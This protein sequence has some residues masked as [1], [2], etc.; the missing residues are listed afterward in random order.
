MEAA[1]GRV[2]EALDYLAHWNINAAAKCGGA[3]VPRLRPILTANLRRRGVGDA[4]TGLFTKRTYT[5]KRAYSERPRPAKHTT[6]CAKITAVPC[7]VHYPTAAPAHY[8][9]VTMLMCGS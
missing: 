6:A 9:I 2:T 4:P 5:T 8:L 7:T 1:R 3:H